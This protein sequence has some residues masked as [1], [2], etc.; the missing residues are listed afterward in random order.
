MTS[1]TA[2][3][4]I[5]LRL[6]GGGVFLLTVAGFVRAPLLPDM[7]RDLD[8][9]PAALGALISVFALGR[10]V[11]DVPVGRLTDRRPPRTM[12]AVA[13]AIVAAGSLATGL[14]PVAAV[15]FVASFAL[16][17]GSSWTNTTG[18]AAFATAPSHRRGLAMSGFAAAL[19]VGQAVGPAV[20]GAVATVSDWRG[21]FILATL[22]A[23]LTGLGLARRRRDR[24]PTPTEMAVRAPETEIGRLVLIALYLLPAVQFA[25]GAALVQTLVPIVGDA[26]LGL[27]AGT[28]GAAIG[29]GGLLR[30]AGALASGW[31]SDRYSR[32]LALLPGLV[33]Q[34]GGLVVFAAWGTAAGWMTAIVLASVGSSSVAIGATVLADLSEGGALGRRLGVFRVVGDAA[35]LVAPVATAAVYETAGRGPS[36]VPLIL[37]VAAVTALAAAVVPETRRPRR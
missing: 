25:I 31:V 20:G 23:G 36:M 32:R 6:V 12:M 2:R 8:M 17:V 18:I 1:S 29:L 35:F 33:L 7:G 28:I 14:A 15:A 22:L 19:M 34:L 37:L 27:T 9:S 30:L 10:I 11:A 24:A 4:H 3:S 26:E 21:A 16:G 13:G 5:D